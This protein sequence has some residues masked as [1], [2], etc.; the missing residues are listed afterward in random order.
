MVAPEEALGRDAAADG[1]RRREEKGRQ[2]AA[3]AHGDVEGDQDEVTG[4]L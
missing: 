4:F 2:R 1:Q 3:E